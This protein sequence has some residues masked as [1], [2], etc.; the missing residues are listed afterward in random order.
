MFGTLPMGARLMRIAGLLLLMLCSPAFAQGGAL[1]DMKIAVEAEQVSVRPL[2][3]TLS[4]VG[5]LRAEE[6]VVLRPEIAGRIEKIHFSDGETVAEG[7]PLFSLD[8]ALLRAEVN[9]AAANRDRSQRAHE[10][11]R[12]LAQRKL[13]SSADFDSAR[14]DLAVDEARLASAQTR[15]DKTVIRAPFSGVAGLRQAS[16]GDY[17]SVGQALVNLVQLD[18]MLVDFQLPEMQLAGLAPGMPVKVRVDAFPARS[19]AGEIMAIDPQI[20]AAGR[21]VRVR[22]RLDNHEAVL[23][24]GLFAR[25]DVVLSSNPAAL[26]VPEQALWPLGDKQH[27]FR[28]EGDTA[29]L[30]QVELGQRLPGWAEIVSGLAPGEVVVTAGQMKLRDGAPVQVQSRD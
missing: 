10:R 2:D 1:G 3:D 11:A 26:M 12:E 6:A 8:A 15:L 16:L 24:P 5:T 9:E 17:I 25:V 22:A 29:K 4:A 18:P 30:V 28:V 19:F 27:V 14:A 20:D 7:A 23:R 13:L 21:S